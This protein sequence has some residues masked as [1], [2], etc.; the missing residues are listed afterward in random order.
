MPTEIIVSII[1]V[2]GAVVGSVIGAYA[3]ANLRCV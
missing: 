2:A 3:S 1:T